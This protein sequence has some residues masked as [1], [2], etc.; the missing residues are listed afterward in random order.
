MKKLREDLE[1]LQEEN[2]GAEGSA[3]QAGGARRPRAEGG[4]EEGRREGEGAGEAAAG[5]RRGGAVAPVVSI[6]VR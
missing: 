6:Q 1:K 3:R 4:G 5:A 2:R